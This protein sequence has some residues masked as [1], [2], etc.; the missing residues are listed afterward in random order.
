MISFVSIDYIFLKSCAKILIK[1]IFILG[2]TRWV[3][4]GWYCESYFGEN[5]A[6]TSAAGEYS[7]GKW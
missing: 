7:W 2:Q 4:L 5:A 1:E 6:G 3:R